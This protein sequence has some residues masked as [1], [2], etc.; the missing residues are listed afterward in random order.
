MLHKQG[1]GRPDWG[2]KKV[3]KGEI[4]ECAVCP[5]SQHVCQCF[6]QPQI[7]PIHLQT[8]FS[9]SR[10]CYRLLTYLSVY[11]LTAGVCVCPLCIEP[12]SHYCQWNVLAHTHTVCLTSVCI[13]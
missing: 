6:K 3:D 11:P 2:C 1:K 10:P 13:F 12:G 5:S 7:R 4:V 8:A 9:E